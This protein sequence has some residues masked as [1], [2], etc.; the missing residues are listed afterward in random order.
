MRTADGAHRSRRLVLER[1]HS[2]ANFKAELRQALADP[3]QLP[4]GELDGAVEYSDGSSGKFLR[5][6]RRD[7]YGDEPIS[8]S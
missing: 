2:P 8:S 6:L 3:S 5:R 1:K 4:E 7:L